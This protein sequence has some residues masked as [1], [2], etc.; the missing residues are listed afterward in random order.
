M[1][2]DLLFR[3]CNLAVL[4]AWL[5]LLLA[6]DWR[7]TRN[8]CWLVPLALAV[9]YLVIVAATLGSAEGSFGSLDGISAFFSNR[10]V[11]LAGWI[12][13]LAFDLFIGSWEMRDS[14]RMKVPRLAVAPCLALTFLLGPVGLLA[15]F[16]L[17]IALRRNY[18][19]T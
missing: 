9:V 14:R 5:L 15:Y 7:W 17:R 11:L 8:V 2:P 19:L 13:Y 6:P 10:W 18:F 16:G 3:V 12:H 4:P 1:T